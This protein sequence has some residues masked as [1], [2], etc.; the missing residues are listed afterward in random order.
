MTKYR[1]SFPGRGTKKYRGAE[2][3]DQPILET[4]RKP[5]LSKQKS[6][7]QSDHGAWEV[8]ARTRDL[9]VRALENFKGTRV[10]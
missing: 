3:G 7:R 2:D 5:V 4:K 10:I 1:K 6:H 8:T 9:T